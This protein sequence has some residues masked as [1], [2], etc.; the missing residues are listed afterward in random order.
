MRGS[1]EQNSHGELLIK[2][3]GNGDSWVKLNEKVFS[4]IIL[5]LHVIY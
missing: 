4:D 1:K 5:T 2:P 3:I